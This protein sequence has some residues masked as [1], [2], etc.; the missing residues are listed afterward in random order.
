L[1]SRATDLET[2]NDLKKPVLRFGQGSVRALPFCFKRLVHVVA[3]TA[4]Q[5]VKQVAPCLDSG[6]RRSEVPPSATSACASCRESPASSPPTSKE[7]N[8]SFAQLDQDEKYGAFG[9]FAEATRE[10]SRKAR[11][12]TAFYQAARSEPSSPERPME[13]DGSP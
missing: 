10:V 9:H 13:R 3:P 11:A 2:A 7:A 8:L 5:Q 6:K 1:H 12:R 4:I